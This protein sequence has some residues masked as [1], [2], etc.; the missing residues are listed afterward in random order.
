MWVLAKRGTAR[1][2]RFQ[3]LH[4]LLFS[5]PGCFALALP[6][7]GSIARMHLLRQQSGLLAATFLVLGML[8]FSFRAKTICCFDLC[9]SFR[10]EI[11]CCLETSAY[12]TATPMAFAM[13]TPTAPALKLCELI[14][15][16]RATGPAREFAD[17]PTA[18]D[19]L[20]KPQQW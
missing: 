4:P 11:N 5:R 10:A 1:S 13:M 17:R 15:V 6:D 8:Y 16:E 18:S 20:Q 9:F 14:E 19:W 12:Y 3:F 7:S 2:S